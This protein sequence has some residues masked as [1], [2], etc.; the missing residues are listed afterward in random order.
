MDRLCPFL[1]IIYISKSCKLLHTGKLHE[2]KHLNVGN[3]DAS[4][5]KLPNY[6]ESVQQMKELT[7]KAFRF[8]FLET[9]FSLALYHYPLVS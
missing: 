5:V 4:N 2:I 1:Q 8:P 6:F 3:H 9:D 7:F